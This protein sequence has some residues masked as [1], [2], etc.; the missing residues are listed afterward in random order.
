[1]VTGYSCAIEG[2]IGSEAHISRRRVHLMEEGCIFQKERHILERRK[3]SSR[4]REV[5]PSWRESTSFS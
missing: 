2:A 1:M 4:S 5:L 3:L